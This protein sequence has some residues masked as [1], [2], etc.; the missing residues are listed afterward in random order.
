MFICVGSWI[1]VLIR[2]L[3]M[4]SVKIMHVENCGLILTTM[5][6]EAFSLMEFFIKRYG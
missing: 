4:E 2:F 1:S 5:R 3:I 6:E